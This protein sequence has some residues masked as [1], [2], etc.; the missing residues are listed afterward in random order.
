MPQPDDDEEE[1]EEPADVAAFDMDED[2]SSKEESADA[3]GLDLGLVNDMVVDSDDEDAEDNHA[4]GDVAS[5]AGKWHKHTIRVFKHLKKCMRDPNQETD[6]EGEELP[7]HVEFHQITKNVNSRRNAACVFFEVLQLK[8]WDFIEVD[9][10]EPY[11]E[12]TI[13]P[14]VRFSEDS[15]N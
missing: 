7:S 9:Q 8:T 2:A 12:I 13:S 1:D 6:E 15:P 11:G 10:Q 3:E 14:G 4:T 5:S